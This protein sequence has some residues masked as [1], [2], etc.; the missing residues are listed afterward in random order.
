M[1]TNNNKIGFIEFH[2]VSKSF[3][4]AEKETE[5]LKNINLTINKGEYLAIVGKSGS[6]K[7]TLLNLLT[8]IDHPTSG[9]IIINGEVVNNLN[10]TQSAVWRGKNIGI[11]FQFFQLIPTLTISENIL[12]AMEFVNSVPKKKRVKRVENLLSQVDILSHKDKMPASL[13][14]GEQ[15]RAAIARALANN[16]D[17]I[18][19]DE[20]TGNL[21]S[22]MSEEIHQLLKELTDAGK[23]VIVVSHESNAKERYDRVISLSDGKMKL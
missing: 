20:P 21:D 22:K 9:D 12:L 3:K 19:A 15:Q 23:T 16:P 6:G 18:V 8:A 7:S 5:V 2:N 4:T 13:S 1:N 14:G 11:I 10:E 17:I